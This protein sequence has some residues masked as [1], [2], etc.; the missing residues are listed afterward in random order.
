[1]GW[2][3]AIFD[4]LT[5]PNTAAAGQARI[6]IGSPPPPPLNT[7]TVGGQK[8]AAGIAFYGGTPGDDDYIFV[9]LLAFA[10]AIYLKIISVLNGAVLELNP[11]I[12]WSL[13]FNFSTITGD[14]SIELLADVVDLHNSATS[15]IRALQPG[16]ANTQEIW[17]NATFSGSWINDPGAF[18]SPLQYRYTVLNTVEFQGIV[19]SPNPFTATIFKLPAGYRPNT[20]Q[21]VWAWTGAGISTILRVD[22]NG[23]VVALGNTA[24]TTTWWLQGSFPLGK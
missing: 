18:Q 15:E 10:G 2:S 16:T 19:Q 22:T 5:L 13:G 24:V 14:T 3:D 4:S 6:F 7:Y 17:H 21:G 23:D 1:M 12:P 20:P 9:G 8:F 11:G